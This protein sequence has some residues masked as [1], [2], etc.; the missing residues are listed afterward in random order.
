MVGWYTIVSGNRQTATA[1]EAAKRESTLGVGLLWVV[2]LAG[3]LAMV[4]VPQS[5]RTL[6]SEQDSLSD[7]GTIITVN[8]K[9]LG[10]LY[11]VTLIWA[12]ALLIVLIRKES[13]N[14]WLALLVVVLGWPVACGVGLFRSWAPFGKWETC[15]QLRAANG[16]RYCF[17]DFSFM[18]GQTMALAEEIRDNR[19]WRSVRVLGTTNGDHPR[20]WASVIRP[21]GIS[22]EDEYGQLYW[23][24]DGKLVGIRYEHKC[25][26]VYDSVS[27]EFHGA[28][29]VEG[30]SPFVCI[31]EQGDLF[32]PDVAAV[33]GEI[34]SKKPGRPGY[35][36]RQAVLDG[37]K[38]PNQGIREAAEEILRAMDAREAMVQAD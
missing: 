21:G 27:G 13:R 22:G 10:W 38:S 37:L 19:L 8:P 26:M 20:H 14:I 1:T 2:T 5:W 33:V 23:T 29:S 30:T 17:M 16:K 3:L 9:V 36:P 7:S 35:P 24:D 11:L 31:G 25:Y 18:Q 6:A 32:E 4:C 34:K 28:D 12:I 15:G